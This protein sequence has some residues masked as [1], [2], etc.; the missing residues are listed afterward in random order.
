[1]SL[2]ITGTK[3]GRKVVKTTTREYVHRFGAVIETI[4]RFVRVERGDIVSL[5]RAGDVIAL[6]PG[7]KLPKDTRLTA[8]VAG[9]GKLSIPIVDLRSDDNYYTRAQKGASA[10]AFI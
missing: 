4:T 6:P 5:G 3:P 2:A 8:S 10:G 9:V 7:S 1:M